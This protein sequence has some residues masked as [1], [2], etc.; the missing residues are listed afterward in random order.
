MLRERATRIKILMLSN[1]ITGADIARKVNRTR[2]CVS[3]VIAGRFNNQEI[4]KAIAEDL[5]C[6]VEDLWSLK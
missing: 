6:T 3:H 4:K 5:G 1:G 2:A